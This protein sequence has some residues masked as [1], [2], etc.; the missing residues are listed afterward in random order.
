[1]NKQMKVSFVLLQLLFITS[2]FAISKLHSQEKTTPDSGKTTFQQSVESSSEKTKVLTQ[3][4]A[5]DSN[6]VNPEST[7]TLASSQED[8]LRQSASQLLVARKIDSLDTRLDAVQTSITRI[9]KKVEP[10]SLWSKIKEDFISNFLWDLVSSDSSKSNRIA[11][12]TS[13]LGLLFLLARIFFY[14]VDRNKKAVA[15]EDRSVGTKVTSILIFWYL[16]LVAPMV[17]VF[18]WSGGLAIKDKATTIDEETQK[19]IASISDE[20]RE[21]RVF[22]EEHPPSSQ[23]TEVP[24]ASTLQ[25]LRGVIAPLEGQLEMI[26]KKT[27]RIESSAE[28]TRTGMATDGFQLFNTLLLLLLL[29]AGWY[30]YKKKYGH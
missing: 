4:I 9:E 24:S 30:F 18:A 23:V 3:E 22:F 1:M 28:A 26:D 16:V 14:F 12:F 5:I 29:G 11:K 25:D 17:A 10:Q 15:G 21:I 27:E 2:A 7:Y 8:S 20:I 6:T 19:R 13:A